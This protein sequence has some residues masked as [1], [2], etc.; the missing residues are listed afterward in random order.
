[1]TLTI[2]K[3]MDGYKNKIFSPIEI[4]K[5][6]IERIKKLDPYINSYITVTE[7]VALKQA[8]EAEGKINSGVLNNLLGIPLSFKDSIDTKDIRT[9]GG[10]VIDKN[11]IPSNNAEIVN[12]LEEANIISLGKN[13]MFEY[14]FGITSRNAFFGDVINPWKENKTAGG[15]SGGSAAAVAA[16]LAMGSIGTD[17]GGSIRVPAACCGVVGL[18]PTYNLVSINGITPLSWTLDHVGP[19]A[20]NVEDTALILEAITKKRYD[21]TPSDNLTG[22]R[23]GLAKHYLSENMDSNVRKGYE[24]CIQQLSS[25]GAII[26]EIDTSFLKDIISVAKV[27]GTSESSYVHKDRISSSFNMYSQD[28]QETFTRS[29]GISALDYIAALKKREE[30]KQKVTEIFNEV[31]IMMTPTTPVVPSDIKAEQVNINGKT[32]SMGDCLIRYVS[33]FNITGHPAL[34]VPAGLTEDEIPIGMQFI[35]NYYREDLLFQVGNCYEKVA[36]EEFYYKRDKKFE[37]YVY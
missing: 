8:R 16:N 5:W 3:L 28:A 1:M 4:T 23:V 13:N 14:G 9:T 7:E 30:L 25:L 34:S 21:L 32:E 20:R 27:F 12:I 15:S 6:Y 36:L 17:A 22:V 26:K 33:L 31:D 10:S 37:M 35:A 2:K 11:R 18:K 19:I 24:K 29:K